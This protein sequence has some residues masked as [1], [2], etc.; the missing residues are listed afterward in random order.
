M[1]FRVAQKKKRGFA[2]PRHRIPSDERKRRERDTKKKNREDIRENK[3][4]AHSPR[5]REREGKKNIWRTLFMR[6]CVVFL[7]RCAHKK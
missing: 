4:S 7:Y 3:K 6:V 1:L 2:C 5:H